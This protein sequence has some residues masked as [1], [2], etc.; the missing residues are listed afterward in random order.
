MV[1]LADISSERTTCHDFTNNEYR[2]TTQTLMADKED[3][4][5]IINN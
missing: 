4:H 3:S 2:Q 1:V 5:G